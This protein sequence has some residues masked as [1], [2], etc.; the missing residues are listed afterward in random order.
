MS[1]FFCHDESSS[2]TSSSPLPKTLD[3]S[4]GL[5]EED[6]SGTASTVLVSWSRVLTT[7]D[8]GGGDNTFSGDTEKASDEVAQIERSR[9]L[10]RMAGFVMV[11]MFWGIVLWANK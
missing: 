5:V 4:T 1:R 11:M 7:R 9:A 2:E 3:S 8:E 6:R 10:S